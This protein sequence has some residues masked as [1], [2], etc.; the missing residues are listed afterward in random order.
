MEKILSSQAF[1][2]AERS[3]RL[4]RFIVESTIDGHADRLKEYE[5]GVEALG[6]PTSFDPR[7]DPIARVE[8]SRLRSRLDRYYA[9]EGRTDVVIISLPKGAYLASFE[10]KCPASR[11]TRPPSEF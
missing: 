6:R 10:I 7:I 8:V 11:S 9:N 1:A 3:R 4:L 2:S 5:L